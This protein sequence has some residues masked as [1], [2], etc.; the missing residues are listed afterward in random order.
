[1]APQGYATA[2]HRG[3]DLDQVRVRLFFSALRGSRAVVQ[4]S[5]RNSIQTTLGL[6]HPQFFSSVFFVNALSLFV[7]RNNL[8]LTLLYSLRT[9]AMVF[10]KLVIN[11]RA[12]FSNPRQ[13]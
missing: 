5:T 1:M 9:D 4:T 10:R 8:F 3:G 2:N 12:S 7:S 13:G 6:S 11:L